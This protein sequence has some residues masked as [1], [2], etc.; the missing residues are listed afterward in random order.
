[1]AI[2]GE[3][4]PAS[5]NPAQVAFGNG[6]TV[7]SGP[8]TATSPQQTLR[9]DAGFWAA[10][11]NT[12]FFR[13]V[14]MLEYQSIKAR[15]DID[16]GLIW[17]VSPRECL[18]TPQQIAGL[19]L[20]V[21]IISFSDGAGFSDGAYFAPDTLDFDVYAAAA[22]GDLILKVVGNDT[23]EM[24]AGQLFTLWHASGPRMY[25]VAS[26]TDITGVTNGQQLRIWPPLRDDVATDDRF[27]PETVICPMM[28][29]GGQLPD[30]PTSYSRF[31]YASAQF[32]EV[33]WTS[34]P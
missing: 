13:G 18:Y 1:M 16:P 28:V 32:I 6:G 20:S 14:A 7:L 17:Y 5:F 25:R 9:N 34:Q 22:E 29:A 15:V 12:M 3:E 30:L 33:P 23:V 10:T 24:Q 8:A 11:Y 26:V 21:E 27:D 19:D 4:L 2:V 31:G